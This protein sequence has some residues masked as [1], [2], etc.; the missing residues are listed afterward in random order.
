MS[1]DLEKQIEI[2]VA[3]AIGF[4]SPTG[5]KTPW[6]RLMSQTTKAIAREDDVREVDARKEMSLLLNIETELIGM[7]DWVDNYPIHDGKDGARTWDV[8]EFYD[9]DVPWARVARDLVFYAASQEE[10]DTNLNV[11]KPK[12]CHEYTHEEK[13]K[14]S[15]TAHKGMNKHERQYV[16]LLDKRPEACTSHVK[17]YF[18]DQEGVR[19]YSG[20]NRAIPRYYFGPI[21]TAWLLAMAPRSNQRVLVIRAAIRMLMRFFNDNR[22]LQGGFSGG[23]TGPPPMFDDEEQNEWYAFHTLR[24]MF[25][26][27]FGCS[28]C[29]HQENNRWCETEEPS[30]RLYDF[31]PNLDGAF[32]TY[33]QQ[34][35]ACVKDLRVRLQNGRKKSSA[36]Q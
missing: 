2:I 31:D 7:K 6:Q 1:V 28:M 20:L 8:P 34:E 10:A 9:E 11:L 16:V 36:G 22:K 26:L 29:Q 18:L 25:R 30:G 13:A 3:K 4:D 24:R 21:L 27:R 5:S 23:A 32:K 15:K 35:T 12:Q 33:K 19:K 17:L 14:W